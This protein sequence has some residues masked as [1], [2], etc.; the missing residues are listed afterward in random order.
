MNNIQNRVKKLKDEFDLLEDWLDQYT[1]L[2]SIATTFPEKE[3]EETENNKIQGCQSIAYLDCHHD[4]KNRVFFY[5]KSDSLVIQG[6]LGLVTNCF[7]GLTPEEIL[8][9]S[10]DFLEIIGIKKHFTSTR[11]VGIESAINKM[12]DYCKV[13]LKNYKRN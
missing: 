10:G 1:Y 7:N 12:K 8:D 3:F 2:V 9:F 13:L 6:L 5:C 4:Q 11:S